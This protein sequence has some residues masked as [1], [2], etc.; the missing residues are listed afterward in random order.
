LPFLKLCLVS[1]YWFLVV[2]K[3]VS[4]DTNYI[5]SCSQWINL[6]Q[7]IEPISFLSFNSLVM[8][9]CILTQRTFILAYLYINWHDE[10]LL[11]WLRQC[12]L[13][14][15]SNIW[16]KTESKQLFHKILK[17]INTQ[18]FCSGFGYRKSAI[19]ETRETRKYRNSFLLHCLIVGMLRKKKV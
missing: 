16:L 1:I 8:V 15:Y 7:P 14:T 18:Y 6:L 13:W 11:C 17:L 10:N 5:H 12:V 2:L 9:W 19:F 3:F 4:E